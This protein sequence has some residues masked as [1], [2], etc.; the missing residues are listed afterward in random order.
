MQ[1]TI[2]ISQDNTK[3]KTMVRYQDG[4]EHLE[5][6]SLKK[7]EEAV[8]GG[9]KAWN[10]DDI[11]VEDIVYLEEIEQIVVGVQPS[12]RQQCLDREPKFILRE[13]D[14]FDG[15][16]DISSPKTKDEVEELWN[17]QTKN[18]TQW[19]QYSDGRYYKIFPEGTTM[20]MTPESLGR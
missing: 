5:F 10:N 18:G 3:F 6:D 12:N 2:T 15:W 1:Y 4:R 13:F 17:Q 16:I 14:K 20:L 11:S 7:A 9:A 19:T 8:V